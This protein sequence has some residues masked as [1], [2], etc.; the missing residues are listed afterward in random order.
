MAN[1]VN[2]NEKAGLQG[3]ML[4]IVTKVTGIVK[5]NRNIPKIPNNGY[6]APQKISKAEITRH[7]TATLIQPK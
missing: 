7:P 3:N 2:P 6:F 4:Q 5:L 1:V